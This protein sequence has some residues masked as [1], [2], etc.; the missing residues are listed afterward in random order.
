M[1]NLEFFEKDGPFTVEEIARNINA[2]IIGDQNFL[3]Q[4]VA[5]LNLAKPSDIAFLSNAKYLSGYTNTKAGACLISEENIKFAPKNINL[6]ICADPYAAYAKTVQKFYPQKDQD[7]YISNKANIHNSAK[8]G[9]NCRIE[10]GVYI[11]KNVVIGDN[12]ALGSNTCVDNNVKI[13]SNNKIAENVTIK[14]SIIGDNCIVH[15]GA[16]IG[17]DGFGYAAG[18]D[19]I[20]K[21]NQLGIVV[22][23]NN[24]EIGANSCIDRGAIS[25]TIIGNN[26]KI[27]NLVQIGHN[28]EIGENSFIAAQAGVAGSSKLGS[29]VMLGGQV[30]ISGHLKIGNGVMIAAQG[31]AIQDID[32]NSVVG[33]TP[34]VPI[35]EW[36]RQS[37]LLKKMIKKRGDK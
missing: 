6:L 9:R 18:K 23:G 5:T 34:T 14:Y 13:G 36:H 35:K 31:G 26:C 8:I 27:D 4:D 15:P 12:V 37:I 2:K 10:A 11:G 28:V 21:V 17:Q 22:I 1:P 20:I 19:G 32:D 33:G 16:R 30:G 3:I 24:V 25:N 29:G 7:E